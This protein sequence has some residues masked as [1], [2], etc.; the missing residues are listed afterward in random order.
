MKT[1]KKIGLV[2]LYIMWGL[3]GAYVGW[4]A[5]NG[6]QNSIVSDYRWLTH[7]T[8]KEITLRLEGDTTVFIVDLSTYDSL[9]LPELFMN[10]D[11]GR[12]KVEF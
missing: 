1:L 11:S 6:V 8:P 4:A 2:L 7:S 9:T 10:M 12:T 5:L 3:G